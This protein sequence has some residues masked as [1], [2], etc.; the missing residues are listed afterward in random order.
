MRPRPVIALLVV[1]LAFGGL[2]TLAAPAR[3]TTDVNMYG[4]TDGGSFTPLDSGG[5]MPLGATVEVHVWA[6]LFSCDPIRVY[7]GDG[8]F[9]FMNFGGSFSETFTHT[10][11][12]EGTYTIYARDCSNVG[13][14]TATIVVG[15]MG[16]VFDPS[17]AMFVPSLFGPILGLAALGMAFGNPRGEDLR[18]ALND[19]THPIPTKDWWHPERFRTF[20]PP[21]MS[22]HWVSYRDIP[23]GAIRQ[24]PEWIKMQ[25]GKPTDIFQTPK[26]PFCGVG[27]LGWV[28][29][30]WFCLNPACPH[31]N[32]PEQPFPRIIHGL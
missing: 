28:A 8:S 23:I 9:E 18:D 12:A 14:Q 31:R 4:Y 32:P 11:A 3:A 30:G 27:E 26:C 10:Y 19:G 22:T 20:V 24:D 21:S 7:W 25:L 1:A 17:S 13:G 15:G 29:G 5:S 16:N 6:D 2:L